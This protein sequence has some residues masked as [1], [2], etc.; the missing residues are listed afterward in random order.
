LPGYN[1]SVANIGANVQSETAGVLPDDVKRQIEQAAA[2][3]GVATGSPGSD[4]SNASMLQALGLTSL[5]LTNLGQTNLLRQLPALPG[6]PIAANPGFYVTPQQ[7]YESGLQNSLFQSAP[8]PMAAGKAGMAAAAAGFGAG[9]GGA[10]GPALPGFDTTAQDN[11][12]NQPG[13]GT[14]GGGSTAPGGG[15]TYIGGVYYGPGQQPGNEQTLNDITQ[16][17][18][19]TVYGQPTTPS[20]GDGTAGSEIDQSQPALYDYTG[21]DNFDNYQYSGDYQG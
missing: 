12:W 4:N 9:R 3:R 10:G 13:P 15:G 21:G 14:A 6:A 20:S 19:D 8:D 17:Y 18:A 7:Q 1:A 11:W 2:E 16:S 5:D